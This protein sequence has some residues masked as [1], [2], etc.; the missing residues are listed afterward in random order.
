L[1]TGR[2]ILL[3]LL[4]TV[5]L[6]AL[7]AP[8]LFWSGRSLAGLPGL[9]FLK[10]TDF[11]RYFER[12]ILL[13]AII[14][15]VPVMRWIGVNR[16][17]ELQI[18]W[19]RSRCW[20][21]PA[22][23]LLAAIVVSAWGCVTFRLG[24]A[25]FKGHP[26]WNLLTSLLLTSLTVATIEEFLFRG[27]IFGLFRQ[28]MP[29]WGAA[30]LV[31]L[32]F[33]IIHPLKPELNQFRSI[34][35]YSG[36]DLLLRS[37]GRLSDPGDLLSVSVPIFVLGLLLA[38]ATVKTGALWLPIGLHAG[39]VFTKMSF[40]KL[41]RHLAEL[42]PWFGSDLASGLGAIGILLLLW[43]LLWLVFPGARRTGHSLPNAG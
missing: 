13:A 39:V 14:L 22:G 31:S 33:S 28:T 3:F 7:L 25:T 23:F 24:L 16:F 4:G 21:L 5:F 36:L 2:K 26:P 35:W 43:L 40:N 17:H 34:T 6:G 10:D 42:P 11:S 27:V 18:S 30:L 12:A 37:I 32:I 41:T 1:A 15:A 19:D 29:V 9:G 8:L 20:F 38:H